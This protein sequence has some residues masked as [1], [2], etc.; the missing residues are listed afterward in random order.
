MR[1]KSRLL[2][3]LFASA[4]SGGAPMKTFSTHA[5]AFAPR[6][7]LTSGISQRYECT[8]RSASSYHQALM[9]AA[10]C[11]AIL[12]ECQPEVGQRCVNALPR[13]SQLQP[14][15]PSRTRLHMIGPG[16]AALH[17]H[18]GVAR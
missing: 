6:L 5:A 14:S 4:S 17:L 18:Q 10:K 2:V 15:P 16:S 3:L 8:T 12:A 11:G 7:K 1:R 9:T 13:S